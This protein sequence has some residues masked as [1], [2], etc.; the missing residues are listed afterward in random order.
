MADRVELEIQLEWLQRQLEER[1]ALV[2]SLRKT[3]EALLGESQDHQLKA[4]TL[5]TVQ[6]ALLRE[7]LLAEKHVDL[8]QKE[9]AELASE[10]ARMHVY[11]K[12]CS[13]KA[14]AAA[15]LSSELRSIAEARA[16]AEELVL[17]AAAAVLAPGPSR[18]SSSHSAASSSR[19]AAADVLGL[20]ASLQA[21]RIL[22]SRL[23]IL[24]ARS[25]VV[26]RREALLA[27][28]GR[29]ADP[30]R[31]APGGAVTDS[32]MEGELVATL[33]SQLGVSA[34]PPTPPDPLAPATD[35]AELSPAAPSPTPLSAVE[36][37]EANNWG[38]P[39]PPPTAGEAVATAS[40]TGGAGGGRPGGGSSEQRV[41]FD[42][43]SLVGRSATSATLLLSGEG[44]DGDDGRRKAGGGSSSSG[45]G[46][47]SYL[48]Y[49]F[50]SLF[51][52]L[53]GDV[54]DTAGSESLS[55]PMRGG[56]EDGDEPEP[57]GGGG[58][59]TPS[60][61]GSHNS[62]YSDGEGEGDDEARGERGEERVGTSTGSSVGNGAG[63]GDVGAGVGYLG[64]AVPVAETISQLAPRDDSWHAANG[65]ANG[66]G[67]PTHKKRV[68]FREP[69]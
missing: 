47:T 68:S 32:A 55:T 27:P 24:A 14:E 51:S 60:R 42:D 21:S 69:S 1:E 37:A 31:A 35:A 7:K 58:G 44:E 41:E 9:K 2:A 22:L 16:N 19:P 23:L 48:S 29:D 52:V 34:L 64:D 33:C 15:R 25:G 10:N 38:G 67:A 56:G 54:S 39:Q 20:E 53:V 57:A 62:I 5:K 13:A 11:A 49:P 6:D 26:L 45:G 18:P 46:L 63:G 66:G 50:R 36:L 30:L 28:P 59:D 3:L 65:V 4:A 8:L 17:A 40:S 43:A 61:G 12:D